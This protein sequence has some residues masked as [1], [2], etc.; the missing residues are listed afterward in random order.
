MGAMQVDV[1]S[2][3]ESLF[4]GKVTFMV[5]PT[6]MGEVGIYPNHEPLLSKVR[7]GVLRLQIENQKEELLL[8]VSGGILEVQPNAV[9]VLSE[10]AVRSD[11]LDEKRAQAAKE[12]A[13]KR[14][15]NAIDDKTTANAQAAL[16]AAI[17]QLKALDYLRQRNH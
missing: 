10:I 2:S 3:E 6:E 5:V 15:K 7:P 17:A 12:E 13:E 9:T 11:D 1:V 16:A 14:L 8:A 4:S